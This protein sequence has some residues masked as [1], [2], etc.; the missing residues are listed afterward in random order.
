MSNPGWC[1]KPIEVGANLTAHFTRPSVYAKYFGL[2]VLCDDCAPAWVGTDY[3]AGTTM[4]PLSCGDWIAHQWN[5]AK[6]IREIRA[7]DPPPDE[8]H[9]D[10]PHRPRLP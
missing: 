9:I 7:S 10:P 2:R 8:P 6:K 5:E 3:I 1:G 4:E